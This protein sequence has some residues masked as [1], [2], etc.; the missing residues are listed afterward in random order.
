MNM[1]ALAQANNPV[2]EEHIGGALRALESLIKARAEA[3]NRGDQAQAALINDQ[4]APAMRRVGDAYPNEETRQHWYNQARTLENASP[5]EKENLLA[6]IGLGLGLL[7]A[8]PLALAFGI[9]G[10]V[11]FTA[12]SIIYAVRNQGN[13]A[14]AV[15]TEELI[16]LAIRRV[17]DAFVNEESRQYWYRQAEDPKNFNLEQSEHMVPRF[18]EHL[19]LE[20]A[21][22]PVPAFTIVGDV[23]S[24]ARSILHDAATALVNIGTSFQV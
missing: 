4:I 15:A 6:N 7:I 14:Q 9:V 17:G 23:M 1:G 21:A 19:V 20:F 8:A 16:P 11:V 5:E 13:E 22:P 3:H 18:G 24:A 10:G 2:L 12:G